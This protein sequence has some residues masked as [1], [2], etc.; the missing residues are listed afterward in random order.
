MAE[1]G[2]A[3]G[4]RGPAGCWSC[5]VLGGLGL[6]AAGLWIYRGPR[7]VLRRGVAP[8]MADIAQIT[9]AISVAAWGVVILV[10]PVGKQKRKEPDPRLTSD[11]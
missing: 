5:R 10:D 1:G 7:A 11:P 4:S 3:A 6:L 2:Q 8:N 9:A